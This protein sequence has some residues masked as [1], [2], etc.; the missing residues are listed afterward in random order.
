MIN[1]FLTFHSILSLVTVVTCRYNGPMFPSFRNNNGKKLKN[2]TLPRV[3]SSDNGSRELQFQFGPEFADY[4]TGDCG[5]KDIMHVN[6]GYYQSWAQWREDDC[7]R[8]P[9]EELDAS[10]YTHL[11]YSFAW[12]NENNELEPY[13]GQIEE[14]V[15]SYEKFMALKKNNPFV[16]LLITVGGWTFSDPGETFRRFSEA[17]AD[18]NRTTFVNSIVSFC[19]E[20]GFEGID[21]DWE[22]PGDYGRGSKREDKEKYADLAEEL[23]EA[24]DKAGHEHWD[25]SVAIPLRQDLVDNGYDLERMAESVDFL[26][27]MAY[28]IHGNWEKEVYAHTDLNE[29]MVFLQ[30][31]IVT[32]KFPPEKMLLG[33][34]PY[35]RTYLMD[36]PDCMTYKCSFK[37][38]GRGGCLEKANF[39]TYF[40][41]NEHIKSGDYTSR[42]AFNQITATAELV[43]DGNVMIDYDSPESMAYKAQFARAACFGGLMWWAVDMMGEPIKLNE[44][45]RRFPT[46]E[47]TAFP[48]EEPTSTPSSSPTSTPTKTPSEFPTSI[49]SSLPSIQPT[50]VPSSSPTFSPSKTP[51]EFPTKFPTVTAKPTMQSSSA[52]SGAPTELPTAMPSGNPTVSP[53]GIPSDEPTKLPTE[54]PTRLPS[55]TPTLS[56]APALLKS[57]KPTLDISEITSNVNENITSSAMIYCHNMYII[58]S[59]LLLPSILSV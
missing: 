38:S 49:P 9:P 21:L 1:F 35:G 2:N 37:A 5:D 36:D 32:K 16:K 47:P 56:A 26:N 45:E 48:T 57:V 46:F 3:L 58:L 50:D 42:T 51:S 52:P 15:R 30:H 53:T 8:L 6:F 29:I 43:V 44:I 28:N 12:I 40:S 34:A 27:V 33:L 25:I 20:H 24:F 18:E 59:V 14:E 10:E 22:F 11:A 41:I 17:V 7:N 19:E 54:L 39:M 23:R 13:N 31:F 4:A 55:T